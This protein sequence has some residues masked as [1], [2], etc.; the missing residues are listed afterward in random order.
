MMMKFL[1]KEFLVTSAAVVASPL[2]GSTQGKCF[3]FLAKL[4]F[5]FR[6]VRLSGLLMP[7]SHMMNGRVRDNRFSAFLKSKL[8][9]NGHRVI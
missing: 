6:L 8:I 9:I 1:E 5:C 7:P 3:L 2:I 4:F